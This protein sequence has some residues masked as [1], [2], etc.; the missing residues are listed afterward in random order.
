MN[1]GLEFT[2]VTDAALER[3]QALG[4]TTAKVRWPG[5]IAE[6]RAAGARRLIV[7]PG[8]DGGGD[9]AAKAE[10]LMRLVETGLAAGFHDIWVAPGNEPNH[11]H[12]EWV[13]YPEVWG[14]HLR[15]VLEGLS[16]VNLV[17]P[18]M[19][20]PHAS[21]AFDAEVRRSTWRARGAHVYW[22]SA[23]NLANFYL[24]RIATLD[25]PLMVL[26]LG[27]SSDAPWEDKFP[28]Y[29]RALLGCAAQGASDAVLFM[30]D[31]DDW[32]TFWAPVGWCLQLRNILDG[33]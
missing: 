6:I 17:S 21:E 4:A 23:E 3:F 24:P 14:R 33:T 28:L 31:Q 2:H 29:L 5:G 26:E 1:L 15:A 16:G 25:Q 9:A 22:D 10:E 13:E 19:A 12:S 20:T 8:D 32:R 18:A 30:V 11:P 27:D 7:R